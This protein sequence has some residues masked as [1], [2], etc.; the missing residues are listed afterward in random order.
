MKT[1]GLFVALAFALAFQ[2]F[3]AVAVQSATGAPVESIA[4]LADR[5]AADRGHI[6]G[7]IARCA[8]STSG[9]AVLLEHIPDLI[10]FLKDEEDVVRY[11][12]AIALGHIGAPAIDA[13][14]ALIVALDE[15]VDTEA[16]KSSESGIR[17]ALDRIDPDWRSRP[18]VSARIKERWPK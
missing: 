13:V 12:V 16:T 6:A 1:S 5:K 2:V 7:E 11:W 4:Q 18:D 9:R 8:S 17:F 3:A 15:R 10:P 14:P